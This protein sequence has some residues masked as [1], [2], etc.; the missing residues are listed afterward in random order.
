M[1]GTPYYIAPEVLNKNYGS[2]CDIW[3]LGVIAFMLLS[4]TAPFNGATNNDI[5]AA[6]KKGEWKFSSPAWMDVSDE[7][8]NFIKCL[9]TIDPNERPT[10]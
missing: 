4:G 8:K 9:L 6:V 7:A 1:I 10:A 2:K 3:S 5:M